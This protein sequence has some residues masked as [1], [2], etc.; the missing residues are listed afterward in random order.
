V[1]LGRLSGFVRRAGRP[2]SGGH[3]MAQHRSIYGPSAVSSSTPQS[4]YQSRPARRP[5]LAC[6]KQA[7]A[8]SARSRAARSRAAWTGLALP[9]LN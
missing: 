4:S 3:L 1:E 8:M 7:R 9:S 6:L 5:C 2:L